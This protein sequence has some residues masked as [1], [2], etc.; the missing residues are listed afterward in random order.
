M[1]ALLRLN[2]NAELPVRYVHDYIA[3]SEDV[4]PLVL[5]YLRSVVFESALALKY[6]L[7]S[8]CCDSSQF[9]WT[10]CPLNKMTETNCLTSL[11]ESF[12]DNTHAASEIVSSYGRPLILGRQVTLQKNASSFRLVEQPGSSIVE[13]AG[14]CEGS[15][16]RSSSSDSF[17]DARVNSVASETGV[18]V[19]S[20][21]SSIDSG[22]VEVPPLS[23]SSSGKK[24]SAIK[25][26]LAVSAE[27]VVTPHPRVSDIVSYMPLVP[28]FDESMD[29]PV[30]RRMFQDYY[31]YP[32]LDETERDL[33]RRL[34]DFTNSFSNVTDEDFVTKQP[35]YRSMANE[36]L[37]AFPSF[38]RKGPFLKS[39]LSSECIITPRFFREEENFLYGKSHQSYEALLEKS[40]WIKN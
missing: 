13:T 22:V 38:F 6:S 15:S 18:C 31:I 21:S 5:E 36:I 7:W 17:R 34:R 9:E 40:G 23:V 39:R 29:C 37:D 28:S 14:S 8:K 33:W 35:E 1:I 20:S 3:V 26:P 32:R 24:A 16:D 25:N 30:L 10:P 19:T 2:S 12:S 27:V 11:L 4:S